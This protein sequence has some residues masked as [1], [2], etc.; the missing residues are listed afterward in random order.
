MIEDLLKKV[1]AMDEYLNSED[2]E[3]IAFLVVQQMD[4]LKD[5]LGNDGWIR[6]IGKAKKIM[7]EVRAFQ[8]G[9]HLIDKGI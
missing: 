6:A 4:H 3:N 7:N 2:P 5:R 1:D 8:H 9:D